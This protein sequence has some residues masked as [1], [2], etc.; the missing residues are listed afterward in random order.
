MEAD[1]R[2][3]FIVAGLLV[4]ISI[5]AW[6]G[7]KATPQFDG[8]DWKLGWSQNQNGGVFEEYV[9]DGEN[10]QNWSELV[11]IQFYP[12]LQ[13]KTNGDIFEASNKADL[14][15]ICPDI[16]WDSVYQTETERMWAFNVQACPGQPDQSEI[17]RLV[18]AEEGFHVFH[19][20]I[21]KAPMPEDKKA[22]W[23]EK[24]KSI[25]IEKD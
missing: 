9:V 6:A 19:Y 24:L 4:L 12:G 18:R 7:E 2:K 16:K 23:T 20:A 8:R 25:T 11:T 10:V 5:P 1:V 22:E 13:A 17:A 14:T 15:R 21:K 3:Y